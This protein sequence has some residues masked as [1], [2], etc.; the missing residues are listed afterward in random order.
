MLLASVSRSSSE[1]NHANSGRKSG[2]ADDPPPESTVSHL[3]PTTPSSSEI[4]CSN[5]TPRV[6]T[7]VLLHEIACHLGD[8]EPPHGPA[9]IV[10]FCELAGTAKGTEVAHV[11]RVVYAKEGVR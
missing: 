11:L 4:N 1:A 3:S 7:E 5:I 6:S 2:G 10:T 8:A 9:F